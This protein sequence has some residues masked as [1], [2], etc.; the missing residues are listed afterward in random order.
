MVPILGHER[1][2]SASA[3]GT[4]LGLFALAATATR[5]ALPWVSR[6]LKE[7]DIIFAAMLVTGA[8]L[9]LYPFSASGWTMSVCSIVLGLFLGAVQPMV[10]SALHQI[11]RAHV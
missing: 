10:M 9:T 7:K 11:G 5:M 2:I 3:I 1:G 4:V 6:R 8:T